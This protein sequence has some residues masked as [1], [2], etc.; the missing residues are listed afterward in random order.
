MWF[1]AEMV[2]TAITSMSTGKACG[3]DGLV[4]EVWRAA[5]WADERVSAQVAWAANMRLAHDPGLLRPRAATE[6]QA[7]DGDGSSTHNTDD[8]TAAA[9]GETRRYR[10]RRERRPGNKPSTTN[11]D[12]RRPD[13]PATPDIDGV[14]RSQRRQK[15]RIHER[16]RRRR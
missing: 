4:S 5:M 14:R 10:P 1:N 9:E 13:R 8:T 7:W 15:G 6:R 12:G 11:N 3:R 16:R 2:A